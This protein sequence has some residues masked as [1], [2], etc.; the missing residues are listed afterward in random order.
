M[1]N[2][3]LI[4]CSAYTGPERRVHDVCIR[5][6]DAKTLPGRLILRGR[7][8]LQKAQAEHSYEMLARAYRN[9]SA[10]YLLT[11]NEAGERQ[12]H[13]IAARYAF[14]AEKQAQAQAADPQLVGTWSTV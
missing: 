5:D 1:N 14:Q 8:L 11:G 7:W 2:R 3:R 9:L 6:V 13:A 4:K 12:A 10:A